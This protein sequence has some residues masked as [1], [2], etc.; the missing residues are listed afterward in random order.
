MKKQM[1]L[2][3]III[4]IIARRTFSSKKIKILNSKKII[5]KIQM[6]LVQTK[7]CK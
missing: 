6:I 2:K 3:M 7:N 4:I 5:D 1:N